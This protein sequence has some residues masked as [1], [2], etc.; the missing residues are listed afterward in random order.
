M[1][2][3]IGVLLLALV[4]GAIGLLLLAFV[5][6]FVGY[7]VAVAFGLGFKV[8]AAMTGVEG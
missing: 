5:V 1:V 2:E 6:G 3:V 8:A 7:F 4:A